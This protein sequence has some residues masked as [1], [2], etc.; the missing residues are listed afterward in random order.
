MCIRDRWMIGALSPAGPVFPCGP[1]GPVAPVTP[2]APVFPITPCIPCGPVGPVAVS[3][4][5]LSMDAANKI[6]A[7][8]FFLFFIV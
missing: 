1:I 7:N 3:Y 4:T 2:V 8:C 6:A 5:H